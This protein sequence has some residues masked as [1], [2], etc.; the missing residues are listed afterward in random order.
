MKLLEGKRGV[1]FGV[2]NHHSIAWA[3][4]RAA[5]A[6]GA[7]LAISHVNERM[8]RRVEPLAR[9]LGVALCGPCDLSEDAQ[10]DAWF[11]QVA[12]VFEGRLDFVVHSV[13]FAAREDLAGAFVD[14][15]RE[16][17]ALAMDVSA[18]SLLGV[19]RRA[20]PLMADGGSVL[21][22]TYVGAERVVGNY[23]VMGPCKAALE[24]AV[25]Y[26]AHGLGPAGVRVNAISAG[27]IKT[28]S[29]AGIPGFRD[30]LKHAAAHAPLGRN[31]T[32]DEVADAAIFLLSD[33]ARAITGEVLHV[34]A[35][36][37][38]MAV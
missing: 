26:L 24:A 18:Y 6:E 17:F 22:M 32:P 3:V 31:V 11:A 30:M 23:N 37:N 10:I 33:R 8:A 7:H 20:A 14:T 9:D 13:A 29:A 4:A 16:G 27:P 12:E 35:G 36:Y 28:L 5:A 25:R 38:I 2:A 1:V 15:S 34:D 19:M 21:T